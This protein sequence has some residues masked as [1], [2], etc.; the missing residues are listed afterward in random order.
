[1]VRDLYYIG[2]RI[3]DTKVSL[4]IFPVI[5]CKHARIYMLNVL[6]IKFSSPYQHSR[7][8]RLVLKFIAFTINTWDPNRV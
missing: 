7:L 5:A 6:S 2:R 8:D 4:V 1:M 3:D